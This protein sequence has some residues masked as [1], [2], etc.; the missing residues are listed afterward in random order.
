MS[1]I[2]GQGDLVGETPLQEACL[3]GHL[4]ICEALIEAGA[5]VNACQAVL[6]LRGMV[7]GALAIASE[8]GHLPIVSRLLEAGADPDGTPPGESCDF[9]PDE[10]SLIR[11]LPA[12]IENGHASVAE[13]LLNAGADPDLESAQGSPFE[14]RTC[15]RQLIADSDDPDIRA[16]I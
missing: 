15:A 7:R 4:S 10:I 14:P 1:S 9:D 6:R 3:H 16:L 2:G 8:A 11:P 5:D 12:S 13:M